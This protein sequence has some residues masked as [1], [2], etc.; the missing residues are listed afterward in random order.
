MV[1]DLLA[2]GLVA[3]RG[4]VQAVA[5]AEEAGA[6]NQRPQRPIKEIG[7]WGRL[8]RP[9]VRPVHRIDATD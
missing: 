4:V 7:G 3:D 2:D 9:G 5:A 1:G 8:D 6:A